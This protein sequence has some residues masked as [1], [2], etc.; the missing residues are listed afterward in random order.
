MLNLKRYL[1]LAALMTIFIVP[2]SGCAVYMAAK[3]PAAKNIELFKVGTPR[4]ALWAEFGQPFISEEAEGKQIEI[5]IFVQ[6]YS[7][8]AKTGRVILHGA[9]DIFTLGLWEIVGTPTELIFNG[10][11]MIFH[12]RYDDSD[13]VDEVNILKKD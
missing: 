2:V 9:A 1:L 6:G 10:N 12:V 11:E 7:K 3:Q 13:H 5:F 8:A 4:K